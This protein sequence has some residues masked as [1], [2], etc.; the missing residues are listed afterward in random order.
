MARVSF[1]GL[2]R[3]AVALLWLLVFLIIGAGVSIGVGA[4]IGPLLGG[5]WWIARNGLTEVI[6]FVAATLVVGRWLDR[7]EWTALGWG[8]PRRVP[9]WFAIGVA[10]GGA[11]A[12]AAIALSLADGARVSLP[13]PGGVFLPVAGAFAV[14]LLA[15]AL[16]EELIFRGYPLRRLADAIG[17]G[18]ATGLLAIGFA[19]A[20]LPNPNVS[21]LGA[22]NIALA[23]VWL[24]VAF[25]SGGMGLAWGLH[26][27]WNV[28][29]SVV[30]DAPVSGVRFDVPGVDY[31][32]GRHAW[33]GG[34][35]FGPE[36]GAVGTLALIA[37]IAVLLGPRLRQPGRWLAPVG[38][39][40]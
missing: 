36:G 5:R 7:H 25:F 2:R 33:V 8:A 21:A 29:L 22:A 37:G 24:S 14:G 19:V 1:V 34:G 38:T 39:T 12:A 6:G 27:G 18:A 17:P 26:A 31:T 23:A 11:M 32:L 13:G 4:I 9:L 16:G 20:H 40:S 35:A 10:L 3:L 15:A 30:F 28:T